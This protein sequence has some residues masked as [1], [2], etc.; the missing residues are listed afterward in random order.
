MENMK[1]QKEKKTEI[2]RGK[3]RNYVTGAYRNNNCFIDFFR[4]I[5][6]NVNG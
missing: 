5:N 6:S 1:K 4:N 2:L 3:G